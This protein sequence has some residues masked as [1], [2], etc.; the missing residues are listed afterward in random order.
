[1]RVDCI[2]ERIRAGIR[3]GEEQAGRGGALPK[4]FTPIRKMKTLFYMGKWP[5]LQ[6]GSPGFFHTQTVLAMGRRDLEQ[7]AGAR[8]WLDLFDAA[9]HSDAAAQLEMGKVC[10]SGAFGAPKDL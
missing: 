4:G 2:S 10:E 9:T 8:A 5:A 3:A 6:D 1:M 7:D